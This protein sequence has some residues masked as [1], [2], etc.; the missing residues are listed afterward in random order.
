MICITNHVSEKEVFEL[1]V[2]EN[3]KR[4]R[5][6][7]GVT[8]KAVADHIG[9][10]EMSYSRFENE[11]KKVDAT[12]LF[13]VSKFLEVDIEIFF[14]DELTESVVCEIRKVQMCN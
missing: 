7:K 13:K 8:Q 3:L 6:A 5:T 10:G 1:S 9:L 12:L 11:A 4:I 2:Q 14:N